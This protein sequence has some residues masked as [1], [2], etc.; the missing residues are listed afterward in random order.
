MTGSALDAHRALYDAVESGDADLMTA[1]WADDPQTSCVHPGA[2]ILRGSAEI[3]RSWVVLMSQIGYIQFFLTDVQVTTLPLGSA[4][5]DTAVV[6]CT[7]SILSGDPDDP[8]GTAD[9]TSFGA[10]TAQSTS[11]L[12]RDGSGWK[13]WLRHA[14]PV[15]VSLDEI[16]ED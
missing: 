14:S 12:V 4:E 13:F 15:A 16:E 9:G 5:P 2:P 11:I 3:V 10:A 6:S 1:L 7:E 8:D